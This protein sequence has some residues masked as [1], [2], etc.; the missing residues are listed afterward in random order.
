MKTSEHTGG[1]A[2]NR[3]PTQYEQEAVLFEPTHSGEGTKTKGRKVKK[4]CIENT[5]SRFLC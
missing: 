1:P 5:E 4:C 2:A 3:T